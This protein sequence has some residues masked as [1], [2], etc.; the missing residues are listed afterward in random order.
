MT[1]YGLG[2]VVV[3]LH[4]PHLRCLHWSFLHIR[5]SRLVVVAGGGFSCPQLQHHQVPFGV[6]IVKKLIKGVEIR[7][8]K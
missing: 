7:A 6:A 2:P 5:S 1:V 8:T 3:S 4:F